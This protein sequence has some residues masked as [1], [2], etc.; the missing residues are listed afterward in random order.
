MSEEII[1]SAKAVQELAKTT[2]Q[3]ITVIDKLG[4]F[5]ARIMKESVDSTCGMLAD[6]LK[7]KRWQRQISL[8]EKAEKIIGD[9][10]LNDGFRPVSPKL[11]LPILHYASIEDEESLHDMWAKLLVASMDPA[12]RTPRTAFIG[13]ISQLEPIDVKIMKELFDLYKAHVE[14]E[15][16]GQRSRAFPDQEPHTIPLRCDRFTQKL[17]VDIKGY[18][19]AIDNLQRLGL[20]RSYIDEGF[21]ETTDG[22]GETEWAD[23]LSS[24]GGYEI[25]YLTALGLDFVKICTYGE[26]TEPSV[27]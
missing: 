6:T 10:R 17:R 14:D 1:E 19:S 2:G 21:F 18:W 7:F 15:T 8:I 12:V 24:H 22:R 9:K 26:F 3:A 16:M 25:L 27:M 13:I 11:A 5:F 23:V 20:C 4:Q